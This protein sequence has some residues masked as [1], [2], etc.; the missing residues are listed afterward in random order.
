M[1]ALQPADVRAWRTREQG[2]DGSLD[3]QPPAAVLAAAGWARSVGGS[4]PYVSLFARARLGREQVDQAAARMEICELPSARG[5]TYVVPAEHFAVALSVAAPFSGRE[6]QTAKK[7]GATDKELNRLS[8]QVLGALSGWAL[9][10]EQI[11]E[12]VG[13]AVLH[14]GEAG[15]KKGL[16]TTLPVALGELQAAGRIR[17][18]PAGGRLDTQRYAYALWDPSPLPR[19]PLPV[20]E[21]LPGLA[22]LYWRWIG[23]ASEAE[24]QKFCVLPLKHVRPALERAGIVPLP[25]HPGLLVAQE[26]VD[27]VL[28]FRRDSKP[29]W[30]L[31][32]NLD[33]AAPL[34]RNSRDLL[35]DPDSAG[36]K[37]TGPGDLPHHAILDRGTLAGCWEF[38]PGAARIVWRVFAKADKALEEEIRRTQEFIVHDLGDCRAY[39]MDTPKQRAARIA[40]L[41]AAR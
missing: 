25:Q 39:S 37:G 27:A 15:K 19:G 2:L 6:R 13:G 3:N 40:A 20:E 31:V 32:A 22:R 11:K 24:F 8:Q 17:R 4:G 18:I 33:S 10:P 35:D 16:I 12:A 38:D 26:E 29:C 34:R 1:Q 23:P 30:R 14:L 9:E 21:A 28:E 7:L 36:L 5:C 41:Q